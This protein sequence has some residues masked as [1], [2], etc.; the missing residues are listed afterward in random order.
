MMNESKIKNLKRIAILA[1]ADSRREL[2]EWSYAN[3]NPLKHHIIIST[4][5]TA[6]V[7]EGTLNTPVL[8]LNHGRSGGY[9]QVKN[10][11]G[12]DHI[13][14]LLIFGNPMKSE[15][16]EPWFTELVKAAVQ[17]DI[18]VAYNQATIATVLDSI[19]DHT[20]HEQ[21]NIFHEA[22]RANLYN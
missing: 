22:M 3:K 2:I 6:A 19:A 13:D 5:R 9:H 11:I 16:Q 21:K 7:L 17:K 14:M 10:L 4:A 15:K 18:V 20:D 1:C 8:N 12:D